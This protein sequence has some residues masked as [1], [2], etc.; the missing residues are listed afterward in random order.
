M[1]GLI[2]KDL[3]AFV[4]KTHKITWIME[5]GFFLLFIIDIKN[6]ISVFTFCLLVV[7][8]SSSGMATTMKELD[9]NCNAGRF[10]LTLPFSHRELVLSRFLAAFSGHILYAFELLTFSI[11]R[12]FVHG[13]FPFTTY[14]VIC[15]A[16]VLIGIC[17]TALNLLASFSASLNTSAILYLVIIAVSMAIYLIALFAGLDI[18]TLMQLGAGFVLVSGTALTAAITL[19]S[20]FL[21][22]KIYIKK[23]G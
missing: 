3:L 19:I 6:P 13:D 8:V 10:N 11:V 21:S 16:G 15:G 9:I 23:L 4:R 18:E 17:M 22:V 14:L 20:Y 7:P 12:Y 1:S 2:Y 5:F